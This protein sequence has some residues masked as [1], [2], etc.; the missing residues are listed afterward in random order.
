MYVY[1][2]VYVCV[3]VCVCVCASH[4]QQQNSHKVV[5]TIHIIKENKMKHMETMV[6][7]GSNFYCQAIVLVLLLLLY[8]QTL[9]VSR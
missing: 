4:N 7:L 8:S 6:D 5:N 3:C 2:C 1:V 9:I